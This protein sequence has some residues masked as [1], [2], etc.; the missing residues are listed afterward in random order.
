MADY[1]QAHRF[2][3]KDGDFFWLL[4]PKRPGLPSTP[5]SPLRLGDCNIDTIP[6]K[7]KNTNQS[8]YICYSFLDV[9]QIDTKHRASRSMWQIPWAKG[10]L[11][12]NVLS[13]WRRTPSTRMTGQP[14]RSLTR[15]VARTVDTVKPGFCTLAAAQQIHPPRMSRSLVMTCQALRHGAVD[16]MSFRQCF[17][18][19]VISP[20]S[21]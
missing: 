13:P 9:K 7:F 14:M 15:S 19:R 12:S 3:W 2:D 11:W 1:Y 18:W 4:R 20:L 21:I 17:R 10:P 6:Q 5:S 8:L 16:L